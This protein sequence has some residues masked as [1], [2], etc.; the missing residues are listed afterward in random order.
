MSNHRTCCCGD[1]CTSNYRVFIPCDPQLTTRRVVMILGT[2]NTCGFNTTSTYLFE[3][4]NCDDYCGTW[5]CADG[6]DDDSDF[7]NELKGGTDCDCDEETPYRL[8]RPTD[9]NLFTEL[10]AADALQDGTCC[11]VRCPNRL[12][13]CDDGPATSCGS[14]ESVRGCDCNG[15]DDLAYWFQVTWAPSSDNGSQESVRDY[16]TPSGQV[17]NEIYTSNVSLSM[18]G[19]SSSLDSVTYCPDG[20][21]PKSYTF[22]VLL[23]WR[24]Q[25]T[26]SLPSGYDSAN[27]D[28]FFCTLTNSY[29]NTLAI[30]ETWFTAHSIVVSVSSFASTPAAMSWGSYTPQASPAPTNGCLQAGLST[31]VPLGKSGIARAFTGGTMGVAGSASNTVQLGSPFTPETGYSGGLKLCAGANGQR[32]ATYLTK[33]VGLGM[34]GLL[35]DGGYYAFN[36]TYSAG[37]VRVDI[38]LATP[39]TPAVGGP[40]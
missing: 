25:H 14:T 36:G 29:V 23:N 15:V 37:T 28:G 16:Y 40:C 27:Y 24:G 7:C 12:S 4:D 8:L 31:G 17:F 9:C 39:P 13:N 6:V 11:D 5:Q 32:D 30:D 2:F 22:K 19:A 18:T 1:G 3:D 38:A 26:L 21:T 33:S 20:V 35:L 34:P 10:V